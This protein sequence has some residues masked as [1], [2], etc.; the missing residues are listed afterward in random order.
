MA[1]TQPAS[2]APGWYRNRADPSDLRYWDGSGWSEPATSPHAAHGDALTRQPKRH[3]THRQR[4]LVGSGVLALMAL[5]A[6]LVVTLSSTVIS[7]SVN[8]AVSSIGSSPYLQAHLT[9]SASGPE[10]EGAQLAL[11]A[12]SLDLRESSQTGAPL[13]GSQGHINSEVLI[14]VGSQV[15]ADLRVVDGNVYLRLN[16][17]AVSGIPGVHISSQDQADTQFASGGGWFELPASVLQQLESKAHAQISAAQQTTEMAAG[18]EIVDEVSSLIKS[19][20]HVLLPGGGFRETGSL[21]SVVQAALPG[22]DALTGQ[23]LH[24]TSVKGSYSVSLSLSGLIVT[25]GSIQVATPDRTGQTETIGLAVQVAHDTVTIAAPS[26][27]TQLDQSSISQL[28]QS[29]SG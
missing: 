20:P 6:V 18:R 23:Q 22:L 3:L 8:D 13:S 5:V 25:G 7:A 12:I 24:P 17:S 26:G 19:S 16:L 27:A 2:F 1:P 15:L 21:D 29:S 11:K 9:A 10:T 4:L 28:L 14:N